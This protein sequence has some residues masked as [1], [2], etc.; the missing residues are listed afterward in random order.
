MENNSSQSIQSSVIDRKKKKNQVIAYL[1]VTFCLTWLLDLALYLSGGLQSQVTGVA[2]QLQML[3][4]AFSAMVLGVFFFKDSPLYRTTNRTISRWFVYYFMGFTILY[5]VAV[6]FAF[7]KVELAISLSQ[8]LMIPSLVGLLLFIVLRI[9]GG[10]EVFA[11]INMNGG[12]AI[13][14]LLYGLGLLLII[15]LQIFMNWVFKLGEP[16]SQTMMELQAMASGMSPE[17][18]LLLAG[19]N[20]V[21]LG[22]FLGLLIAFGEEYGWRGYLQQ[23]LTHLGRIRGVLLLGVIWG[24]WHWPIIWMGY[25][26]PDQPVLGSIMMV[27]FCIALAYFLAYA[28][29]KTKSVWLC[30]FLHA[31]L[32]QSMSFFMGFVYTP[33]NIPF[34]FG[35]GLPGLALFAILILILLRDPVWKM[36]D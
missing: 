2:L 13:R 32:N 24:V 5:V 8:Y 9:K 3:I 6:I 31:L 18:L 11:K 14:W 12:K 30:A 1:L 29:F 21:V 33:T 34:S 15:A 36:S 16:A 22:P 35:M 20:T 10:R 27:L 26:Y 28:Y 25:N 23:E 4:P 17:L 19:V 7:L